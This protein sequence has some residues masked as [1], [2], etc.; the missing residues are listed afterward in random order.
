MIWLKFR[1]VLI[2]DVLA[3]GT[4]KVTGISRCVF[5]YS[6]YSPPSV[7]GKV[8]LFSFIASLL[9]S[10]EIGRP[11]T[12]G[13]AGWHE[14]SNIKYPLLSISFEALRLFAELLVTKSFAIE[15]TNSTFSQTFF[16]EFIPKST[17]ICE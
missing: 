8:R 4:S 13:M 12:R 3:F 10:N 16:S 14:R 7:S 15:F 11:R 6:Y 17:K 1:H 9:T 2:V 5:N